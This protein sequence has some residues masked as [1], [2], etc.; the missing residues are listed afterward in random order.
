MPNLVLEV[1]R[2]QIFDVAKRFIKPADTLA[3]IGPGIRPTTLVQ[4]KLHMCI[5]PYLEYIDH[6]ANLV[7]NG[8]KDFKVFLNM[9]WQRFVDVFP[10]ASFD[11]ITLIDVVEHLEKSTALQL[12]SKTEKISRGQVIVFTPLGF[13]PQCHPDGIDAWGLGGGAFQEHKSGWT[14][15]DFGDDY[16]VLVCREFHFL[17][18]SGKRFPKPYGAFL[19]VRL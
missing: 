9:D 18:H 7:K 3:D 10:G 19:A 5:E 12:L 16:L 14:P 15:Q 2:S 6:Y 11:T 13:M 1:S 4:S 17:D 8:E